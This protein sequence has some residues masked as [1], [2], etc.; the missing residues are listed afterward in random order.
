MSGNRRKLV[1][2]LCVNNY[3]QFQQDDIMKT[4]RIEGR[5][6]VTAR[7]LTGMYSRRHI[8][9]VLLLFSFIK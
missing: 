6:S 8:R 1:M 9:R 7:A 5:S 2:A 4:I 3:G